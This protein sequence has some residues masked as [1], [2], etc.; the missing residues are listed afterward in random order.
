VQKEPRRER[1]SRIRAISDGVSLMSA[2]KTYVESKMQGV[3]IELETTTQELAAQNPCDQDIL[4][5]E[6]SNLLLTDTSVNSVDSVNGDSDI[7]D[8]PVI[9]L[10]E[11]ATVLK[12]KKSLATFDLAL[13][14][15]GHQY[16]RLSLL[17]GPM[18][19]SFFIA[20]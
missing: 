1:K 2:E 6:E 17:F 16:H 7:D 9:T 8:V 14:F 13:F 18:M 5:S 11:K 10:S 4:F 12:K 20:M 3:P 19:C 15:Q